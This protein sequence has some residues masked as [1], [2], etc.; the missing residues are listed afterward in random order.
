MKKI[1]LILFSLTVVVTTFSQENSSN[2]RRARIE[3]VESNSITGENVAKPSPNKKPLVYS[4]NGRTYYIGECVDLN[5]FFGSPNDRTDWNYTS[6]EGM[7]DV[8]E[9]Y[10]LEYENSCWRVTKANGDEND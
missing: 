2:V 9:Y 4:P 5:D 7:E 3:Q 1:L 6:I 8:L 10:G